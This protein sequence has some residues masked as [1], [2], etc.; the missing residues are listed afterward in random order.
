MTD[1]NEQGLEVLTMSIKA[2]RFEEVIYKILP[3]GPDGPGFYLWVQ[4]RS[5]HSSFLVG[6]FPSVEEAKKAAGPQYGRSPR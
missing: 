5:S 1:T 3:Q 4:W 6:R 2:P